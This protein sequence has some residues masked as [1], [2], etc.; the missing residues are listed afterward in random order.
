MEGR[1]GGRQHPLG[2]LSLG[3]PGDG[4]LELKN[5]ISSPSEYGDLEARKWEIGVGDVHKGETGYLNKGFSLPPPK[6][7]NR[8][9]PPAGQ[10]QK[11]INSSPVLGQMPSTNIKDSASPPTPP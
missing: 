8:K 9:L 11:D 2:G 6:E 10:R 1:K 5:R 7:Y 4:I 3:P